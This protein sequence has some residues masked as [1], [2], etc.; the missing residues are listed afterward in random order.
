MLYVTKGFRKTRLFK[1]M[2][3]LIMVLIEIIYY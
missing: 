2:Y 1:I 3:F